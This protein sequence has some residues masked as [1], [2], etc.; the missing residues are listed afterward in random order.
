VVKV[1]EIDLK[2]LLRYL[3]QMDE[4]ADLR[5]ALGDVCWRANMAVGSALVAMLDAI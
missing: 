3:E 1:Y 4:D 5:E 2:L